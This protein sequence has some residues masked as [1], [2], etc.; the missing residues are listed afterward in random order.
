MPASIAQGACSGVGIVPHSGRSGRSTGCYTVSGTRRAVRRPVGPSRA[1]L[2]PAVDPGRG[3]G[4]AALEDCSD[5]EAC[6]RF[7]YDLRW[8]YAAGVDDEAG[9]FVHT[10]LVELRGRQLDPEVAQVA[11][12]LATVIGQDIQE[13][14]DGAL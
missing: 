1:P 11:E 3:D 14:A 12:L 5:R 7:A 2:G 8:R 4:A 13:T 6:D 10:V 9:S